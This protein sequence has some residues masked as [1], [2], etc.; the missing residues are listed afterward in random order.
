MTGKLAD[1]VMSVR[2]GEQIARKYQPIVFNPSTAAQVA[3]RAKMKLI[4]QL[5][6]IFAPVIAIPR[7]GS[8]SGRN[9]FTKKN[10]KLLTYADNTATCSLPDIQLTDSVVG[11]PG[12][13]FIQGETDMTVQ[14]EAGVGG[15]DRMVYAE[16]QRLTDGSIEYVDS[17]VVNAPGENGRFTA[18]FSGI[19]L[20]VSENDNLL[21]LAYGIRFNT[22]RARVTYDNLNVLSAAMVANL[23]ANR[24]LTE[25]DVTL[26]KTVG[27]Y[28]HLTTNREVEK[29]SKKK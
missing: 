7:R 13:A 1:T 23:I 6:A 8:V 22:E 17:K 9:L 10:F 20:A 4:S 21:Y 24:T 5:S 14:L 16:Y 25:A 12:I 29:E 3:Q 2:N 26:T 15:I 27:L 28:T 19:P 18:T 11:I